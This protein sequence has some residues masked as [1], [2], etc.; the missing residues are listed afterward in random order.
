MKSRNGSRIEPLESRLLMAVH[1][2]LNNDD[3]GAGSLRQAI[4]DAA[5]GDTID[6]SSR[7]GTI[8]LATRIWIDK[9]ISVIGPGASA[10]TLSG[11]NVNQVFFIDKI[12][13]AVSIAH[14]TIADG[15][16]DSYGAAIDSRGNSLRLE[17][18]VVRDNVSIDAGGG[19]RASGHLTMVG[20]RFTGNRVV[21]SP[22]NGSADGGA[23]FFAG[24]AAEISGC[25]FDANSVD[26]SGPNPGSATGGGAYLEGRISLTNCTFVGN[27][28]L[29]GGLD[30]SG[31]PNPSYGGGLSARHSAS[32][33]S[34]VNCTLAVNHAATA[35]GLFDSGVGPSH[36]VN[37]LI[38]GNTA[39]PDTA[40]QALI[41]FTTPTGGGNIMGWNGG[42]TWNGIEELPEGTAVQVGPLANHGGTASTIRPDPNFV[43][44]RGISTID[45]TASDQRGLP[46][47]GAP[48]VGAFEFQPLAFQPVNDFPPSVAMGQFVYYPLRAS[49]VDGD[50][51]AFTAVALPPWLTLVDYGDG[52]GVLRG[53]PADSD[54]GLNRIIVQVSDGQDMASQT[55]DVPVILPPARLVDGTLT[56]AGGIGADTIAVWIRSDSRSTAQVRVVNNGLIANFAAQAVQRIVVYGLDDDDTITLNTRSIPTYALGGG[57]NDTLTGGDQP[58]N[59]VGGGGKDSISGGGGDDRLSGLG[60][61][62]YLLGGGGKDR[63]LGGDGNDVLIG[64]TGADRFYG[65]A[66]NDVLYAK[67]GYADALFGGEGDDQA[68]FDPTDLLDELFSTPA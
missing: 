36:L 68:T 35:G 48:D 56:V 55:I 6:L 38:V 22:T 20:C 3:S 62:D 19:V 29:A 1:A 39:A 54:G 13:E 5:N 63:L 16:S 14:L 24:V 8:A 46:R 23:L 12:T 40:T 21:P 58:D 45:V 65:E 11:R 43:R 41:Y 50:R 15:R 18:L 57:G 27:T 59:L 34:M 32:M 60:G 47:D 51:W 44:D 9:S 66:G 52:T 7:S 49:S 10:L 61:N 25:T 33:F 26:C 42:A 31:A 37:N 30:W 64:N 2:V 4:A 28:A 53:T 67:D 17:H